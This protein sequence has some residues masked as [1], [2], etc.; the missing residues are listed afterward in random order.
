M[1]QK[2]Q[3]FELCNRRFEEANQ[4]EWDRMM[5]AAK[6]KFRDRQRSKT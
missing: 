4:W 1:G 2:P 6:K 5:A 3:P